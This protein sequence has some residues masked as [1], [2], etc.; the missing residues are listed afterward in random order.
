MQVFYMKTETI[1]NGYATLQENVI[2]PEARAT[3]NHRIHPA[4]TVQEVG[5]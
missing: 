2:A 4:Q 5:S 3:V 1:C